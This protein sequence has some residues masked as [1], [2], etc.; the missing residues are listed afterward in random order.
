MQHKAAATLVLSV[1][2]KDKYVTF[3][4]RRHIM[5]L[6]YVRQQACPRDCGRRVLQAAATTVIESVY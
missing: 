1:S 4:C 2:R 3:L 5:N 6:E